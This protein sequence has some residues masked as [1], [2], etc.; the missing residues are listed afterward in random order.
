MVSFITLLNAGQYCGDRL[1]WLRC[2]F[3]GRGRPKGHN[4]DVPVT[5]PVRVAMHECWSSSI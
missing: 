4:K 2:V 3:A 5:T 1:L